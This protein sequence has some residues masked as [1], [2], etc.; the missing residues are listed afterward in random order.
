MTRATRA[1]RTGAAGRALAVGVGLVLLASVAAPA[2]S[3]APGRP[4]VPD[5]AGPVVRAT[6]ADLEELIEVSPAAVDLVA[7][8]PGHA[9]TWTMTVTSTAG[10]A[11]DPLPIWLAVSGTDGPLLRGEHPLTL[12]VTAEDGTVLLASSNIA[13]LLGRR[14]AL[15]DLEGSTTVT[16]RTELPAEASDE[17]RGAR[18]SVRL[19]VTAQAP[20]PSSSAGGALARTGT[21]AVGLALVAVALLGAGGT[22]L[23][24]R[25]GAAPRPSRV[26]TSPAPRTGRT[27]EEPR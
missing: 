20:A 12:T 7:P 1:T 2:A 26:T 17:Y 25:R 13:T 14:V 15:P 24:S 18:G 11:G 9:V 4:A 6:G 19:A 8:Q 21:G 10:N 23:A 3:A 22:A 27:P 5:A 16:A